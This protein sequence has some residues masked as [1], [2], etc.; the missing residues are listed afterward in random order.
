MFFCFSLALN[1]LQRILEEDSTISSSVEKLSRVKVQGTVNSYN[2]NI[3]E[4]YL[5]IT[6]DCD[7]Q[8]CLFTEGTRIFSSLAISRHEHK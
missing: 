5:G 4:I 1:N 8:K 7:I 3:I 6:Y 2:V